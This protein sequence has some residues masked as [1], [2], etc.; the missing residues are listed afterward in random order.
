MGEISWAFSC[1]EQWIKDHGGHCVGLS[2]Q[3]D[4]RW[5]AEVVTSDPNWCPQRNMF[6]SRFA[7]LGRYPDDEDNQ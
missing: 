7:D 5:F 6:I 1:A 2:R 3:M 4:G